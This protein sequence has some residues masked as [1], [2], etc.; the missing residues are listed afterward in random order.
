MNIKEVANSLC[1]HENNRKI[2]PWTI[3]ITWESFKLVLVLVDF[4]LRFSFELTNGSG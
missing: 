3:S 4:F 1:Q 2:G